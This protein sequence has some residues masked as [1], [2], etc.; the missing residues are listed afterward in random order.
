[1]INSLSPIFVVKISVPLLGARIRSIQ[2]A[3]GLLGLGGVA[4]LVLRSTARLDAIGLVAMLG[5]VIM[6][7]SARSSPNAGAIHRA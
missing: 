3:A 5:G 2:I 7:G 1:V 6:M 4:L